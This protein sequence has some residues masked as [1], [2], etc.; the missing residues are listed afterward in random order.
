M[1]SYNISKKTKTE[2]VAIIIRRFLY[3]LAAVMLLL[4]IYFSLAFFGSDTWITK[5]NE[6]VELVAPTWIKAILG[7]VKEVDK[8]TLFWIWFGTLIVTIIVTVGLF[9]VNC[10]STYDTPYQAKIANKK[11]QKLKLMELKLK[12]KIHK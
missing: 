12:K 11:F 6:T 2:R 5:T 1:I 9:V 3:L 10:Y 4:L 7:W 8:T